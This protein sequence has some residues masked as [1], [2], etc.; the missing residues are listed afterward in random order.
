[1]RREGG[2][3]GDCMKTVHVQDINVGTRTHFSFDLTVV[4]STSLAR[5]T[6]MICKVGQRLLAHLVPRLFINLQCS[7]SIDYESVLHYTFIG[8]V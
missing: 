3:E 6:Q 7:I 5:S 4:V 1:M 8:S 2:R